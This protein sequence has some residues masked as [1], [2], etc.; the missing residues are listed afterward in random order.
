[1]ITFD[2]RNEIERQSQNMGDDGCFICEDCTNYAG[3]RSCE[4]NV[5]IAFQ[6]ANMSNC[7]YRSTGKPCPH[8]GRYVIVLGH[9]PT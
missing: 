5:F 3:G 8:C 7:I 4:K 1:M 6:G 9:W 2:I